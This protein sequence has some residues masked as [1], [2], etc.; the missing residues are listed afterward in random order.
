L[1]AAVDATGAPVSSCMTPTWADSDSKLLWTLDLNAG[2]FAGKRIV[3][4]RPATPTGGTVN[5]GTAADAFCISPG[6]TPWY[7]SGTW[8]APSGS[9]DGEF[10]IVRN[11]ENGVRRGVMRIVRVGPTGAPRIDVGGY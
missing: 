3:A 4:S 11:D 5:L 9:N 6:G 10:D 8:Q 1:R 7:R 2:S